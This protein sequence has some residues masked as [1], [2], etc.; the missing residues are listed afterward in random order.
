MTTTALTISA[1]FD[2]DGKTWTDE[3][4]QYIET[5]CRDA[6]VSVTDAVDHTATLYT[7]SDGSRIVITGSWWDVVDADGR[8]SDGTPLTG[9]GAVGGELTATHL[10]DTWT[11]TDPE[12]GVW[13]PTEDADGASEAACRAA[14]ADSPMRGEWRD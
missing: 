1:R 11:L 8:V 13:W 6:A 10:H 2:D 7:F 3:D 9:F 12:G 5:V 14:Y 4:G